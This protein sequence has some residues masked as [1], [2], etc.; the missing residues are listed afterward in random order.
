LAVIVAS[1]VSALLSIAMFKGINKK[2][3]SSK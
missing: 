1:V 2:V 3:S